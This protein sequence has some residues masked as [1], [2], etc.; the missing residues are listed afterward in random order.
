[1]A[2]WDIFCDPATNH[3]HLGFF[4]SQSVSRLIF[5]KIDNQK[6]FSRI[7]RW[8]VPSFV[9]YYMN[10]EYRQLKIL[11]ASSI[12]H[13]TNKFHRSMVINLVKN[14]FSLVA[15]IPRPFSEKK[16]DEQQFRGEF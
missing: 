16:T 10:I 12:L 4:V 3:L 1:M 9:L 5:L 6:N 11:Q 15:A 7:R 13:I 8:P 14:Y 2:N